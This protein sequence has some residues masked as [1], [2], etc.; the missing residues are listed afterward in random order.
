TLALILL[1]TSIFSTISIIEDRQVGF[2]QAVLV[3]PVSRSAI[4]L[5]KILGGTTLALIQALIFLL[6]APTVGISLSGEKLLALIGILF[7]VAFALTAVGFLIAWKMDSTQGFHAIMNLL[8]M[9]MWLLSGAFFPSS[10]APR[11]IQAIIRANPLTYGVGAV[12]RTLYLGA[13]QSAMDIPSLG[14]CVTISALFGILAFGATV[15]LAS[16]PMK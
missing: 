8:L 11:W 15:Y 7:L 14:A 10:G 3:A 6:L 12:R 2:L 9:P 5:G 13:H 1:F 16:R 4:T